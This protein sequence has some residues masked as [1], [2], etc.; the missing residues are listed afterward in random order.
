MNSNNCYLK[1]AAGGGASPGDTAQPAALRCPRFT[2]VPGS[3]PSLS[4]LV[5]PSLRP[6]SRRRAG[7]VLG[8]LSHLGMEAVR[9]VWAVHAKS[10]FTI[11]SF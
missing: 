6:S 9:N 11:L 7:T 8:S 4:L 5:K 10:N 3:R 1:Q 2:P